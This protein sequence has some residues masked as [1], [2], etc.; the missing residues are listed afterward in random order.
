MP[1]SVIS[2]WS[3]ELVERMFPGKILVLKNHSENR[4]E[5]QG[6]ENRIWIK[7]PRVDSGRNLHF[8]DFNYSDQLLLTASEKLENNQ[9]FFENCEKEI[10][11]EIHHGSP[12]NFSH[13]FY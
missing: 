8:P 4:A 10:Q 11:K 3:E 7:I 1:L 12:R 5:N 13:G 9:T 6:N 2:K